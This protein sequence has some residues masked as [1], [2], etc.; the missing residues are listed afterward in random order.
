VFNLLPGQ[1]LGMPTPSGFLAFG[2]GAI[3]FVKK[4]VKKGLARTKI[5]NVFAGR[6]GREDEE[7]LT[8][9][10]EFLFLEAA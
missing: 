3:G 8:I 5:R 6:I 10:S 1:G 9:I 7:I 4:I 2:L